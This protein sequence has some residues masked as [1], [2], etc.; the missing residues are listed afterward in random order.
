MYAV[1]L[2]ENRLMAI[3]ENKR[4]I[5]KGLLINLLAFIQ[6]YFGEKTGIFPGEEMLT[7]CKTARE[8]EIPVALIDQK[9]E[10]TLGKMKLVPLKEK[11]KLVLVDSFSQVLKNALNLLGINALE[12]M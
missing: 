10:I 4:E 1:E 3:L 7:A 12:K 6:R 2:D 8:K 11:F 9:I 5:N